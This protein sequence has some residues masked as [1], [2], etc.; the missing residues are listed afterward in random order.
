MGIKASNNLFYAWHYGDVPQDI[1]NMQAISST[2]NLPT[3]GTELGCDHFKAAAKAGIS[4]SY[5]HYS[6]YCNTGPAFGNRAVPTDTFGACILG[7][8]GGDSSACTKSASPS[9]LWLNILARVLR[10]AI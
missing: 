3:F 9:M 2:W 10:P 6:S 7:W 4:H 5:W 8:A 1:Q